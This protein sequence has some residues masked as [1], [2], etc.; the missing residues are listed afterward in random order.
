MQ[1]CTT[2]SLK[3]QY[4]RKNIKLIVCKAKPYIGKN[5]TAI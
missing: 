5:E 2:V 3:K 4:K 1:D